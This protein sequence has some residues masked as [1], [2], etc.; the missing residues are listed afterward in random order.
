MKQQSLHQDDDD[1]SSTE[2]N[3]TTSVENPC[4]IQENTIFSNFYNQNGFRFYQGSF[5]FNMRDDVIQIQFHPIFLWRLLHYYQIKSD[6]FKSIV[7]YGLKT[8]WN[9]LI[10]STHIQVIQ[11]NNNI[12]HN[13]TIDLYK[14]TTLI[15]HRLYCAIQRNYEYY[16]VLNDLLHKIIQLLI[17]SYN[18]HDD[19]YI[20]INTPLNTL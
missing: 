12:T 10:H 15:Y 7:S 19:K 14:Q 20:N 3:V 9:I 1:N 17:H 5:N 16:N 11:N 4:T 6:K 18:C 8:N 13:I 2:N